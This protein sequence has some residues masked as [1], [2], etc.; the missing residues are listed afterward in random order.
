MVEGKKKKREKRKR[1]KEREELDEHNRQHKEYDTED[2]RHVPIDA[3]LAAL[4]VCVWR[5]EWRR[6]RCCSPSL[7]VV[8]G[9]GW[10]AMAA[11]F[12]S[13]FL[14]QAATSTALLLLVG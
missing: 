10:L 4:H 12:A 8:D 2:L 14:E 7:V 11:G 1:T 6:W 9:V 3:R 13:F 5:G